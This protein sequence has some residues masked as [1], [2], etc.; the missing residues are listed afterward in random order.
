[1]ISPLSGFRIN[2]SIQR[3]SYMLVMNSMYSGSSALNER[4]KTLRGI[5]HA[6]RSDSGISAHVGFEPNGCWLP[7][8]GSW[9]DRVEV[10]SGKTWQVTKTFL[11]ANAPVSLPSAAV[12]PNTEIARVDLR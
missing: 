8:D 5:I 9:G 4:L 10:K 6:S 7:T 3:G 11:G 2:E 1:M 12:S